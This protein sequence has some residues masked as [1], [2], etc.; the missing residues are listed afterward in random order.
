MVIP[1]FRPIFVKAFQ[2]WQSDNAPRLAA[3][4]AFYAMLALAPMVVLAVAVA[5]HFLGQSQGGMHI[6]HVMEEYLGKSGSAFLENMIQNAAQPGTTTIA[7][8]LSLLVA[9]IG[10]V[11][12][13]EQLFEAV[14]TIWGVKGRGGFKGFLINKVTSV[15]MFIVFSAVFVIWLAIDSWLG[16]VE[17][18]THGFQGWQLISILVSVIFLTL[19]F[20]MSFRALPRRMVA[21]SDVWLGAVVTACGFALSKLLLSLYFSFT[22]L[23]AYGSAGALVIILLWIY[24]SAQI[25]FFGIELTC[26]YAHMYGS[27]TQRHKGEQPIPNH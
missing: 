5:S 19:V 2:S 23:T 20:A 24:Y 22:S 17:V 18:H 1:N 6:V 8:I 11:N 26:T 16:W 15:M 9:T 10:A 7:T 12:L 13:F 14:N 3:A 25:Y 4:F 21:W 27:Q